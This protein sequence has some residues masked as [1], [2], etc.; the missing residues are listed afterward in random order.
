MSSLLSSEIDS[1]GS[2]GGGIFL[3]DL[4]PC[5][6]ACKWPYAVA[7]AFGGCRRTLVAVKPGTFMNELSIAEI[8]VE[9]A[10]EPNAACQKFTKSTTES[11]RIAADAE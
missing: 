10:G 2:I 9:T 4:I 1:L 7:T 3:V 5:R 8:N 6:V 11:N